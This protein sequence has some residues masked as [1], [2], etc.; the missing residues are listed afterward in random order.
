MLSSAWDHPLPPE[1][2]VPALETWSPGSSGEGSD[3]GGQVSISASG[4][5]VNQ[6]WVVGPQRMNQAIREL[7]SPKQTPRL[8]CAQ[9]PRMCCHPEQ[10][11][12]PQPESSAILPLLFPLGFS[13]QTQ[14]CQHS[15]YETNIISHDGF[16]QSGHFGPCRVRNRPRVLERMGSCDLLD[17]MQLAIHK[18]RKRFS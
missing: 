13:L 5:A 17:P 12:K 10:V 16:S 7:L 14:R 9:S 2:G 15:P 8:P 11:L 4:E 1:H 3:G 18:C 6:L